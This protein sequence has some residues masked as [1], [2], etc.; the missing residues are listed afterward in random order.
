MEKDKDRPV[1]WQGPNFLAI[2]AM[3]EL[4]CVVQLNFFDNSNPRPVG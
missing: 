2:K 1:L 3:W 4:L